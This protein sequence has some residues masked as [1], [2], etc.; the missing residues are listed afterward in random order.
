MTGYI[1]AALLFIQFSPQTAIMET[2]EIDLK[3]TLLSSS[4]V[5]FIFPLS[6]AQF[7]APVSP[8]MDPD[9]FI[10]SAR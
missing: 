5:S 7:P 2:V 8:E 10:L 1:T 6:Q 3:K 4:F 9:I